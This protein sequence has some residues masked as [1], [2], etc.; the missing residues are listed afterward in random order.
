MILKT[1]VLTSAA[2]T[3]KWE[4]YGQTLAWDELSTA[5]AQGRHANSGS[6][7]YFFRSFCIKCKTNVFINTENIAK[8]ISTRVL[9]PKHCAAFCSY[10]CS[11]DAPVWWVRG[12]DA[13]NGMLLASLPSP[14]L[15]DFR[16]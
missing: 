7:L 5:P 16:L 3:L 14:Y 13:T 4:R 8:V 15:S 2:L 12:G 6:R 11:G 1:K 9:L 10:P